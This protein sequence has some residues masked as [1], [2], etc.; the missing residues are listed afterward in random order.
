M[1]VL[2]LSEVRPHARRV[3]VGQFDG[4][5]LGHREVIA[6]NGTVL[7]FEPHPA[8]VVKPSAAPRLLTSFDRKRELLEA[9]GVEELVVIAFD[10]EFA[11]LTPGEFIDRVLVRTL[12][13][14]S[15]SVGVNFRFGHGARGDASRLAADPRFTT[16][17]VDLVEVGGAAVSSSRIRTLVAG[18]DVRAAAQ[19]LGYDF[20]L[21]GTVVAGDQRGRELGFPTANIVPDPMLACPGNGV[22]ACRVGEHMAAVNVGVR[23]TFGAG[24]GTLVEAFLLDFRGDLYGQSLSVEFVA[25][26]RDEQRFAA[27][28]ELV[29]Q[30]RRD[31]EQTRKLLGS[32]LT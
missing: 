15:V 32:V 3:A 19:L 2:G 29:A 5:H 21:Q 6:D 17:V 11:A 8:A 20:V 31:V 25:R 13:A 7:T 9:L 28:D 23:P 22:Y 16:R 27:V 24:L 4:V 12:A 18:G 26:L 1:R 10:A 14:T 30:M